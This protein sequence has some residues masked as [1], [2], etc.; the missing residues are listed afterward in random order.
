MLCK[1][2][3]VGSNLCSDVGE[4]EEVQVWVAVKSGKYIDS[5]S[6]RPELSEK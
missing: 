1:V 2:S 4:K 3:G 6:S 5:C